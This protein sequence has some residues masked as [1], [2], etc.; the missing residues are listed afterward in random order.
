MHLRVSDRE[1]DAVGERLREAAA[2]GRLDPQ[3]LNDRLD[4]AYRARTYADLVR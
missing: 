1:R 3:E 2:D 4:A